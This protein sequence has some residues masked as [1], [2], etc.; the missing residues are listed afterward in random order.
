MKRLRPEEGGKLL[1]AIGFR[2]GLQQIWDGAQ[3]MWADH[4][5]LHLS[6]LIYKTEMTEGVQLAGT[7]QLT[8]TKTV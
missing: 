1:P 3:I 8:C 5:S 2:N 6:G 7:E 4:L